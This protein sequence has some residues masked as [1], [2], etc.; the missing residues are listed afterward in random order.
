MTVEVIKIYDEYICSGIADRFEILKLRIEVAKAHLFFALSVPKRSAHVTFFAFPKFCC[1][2][3]IFRRERVQRVGTL[4][5]HFNQKEKVLGV[6]LSLHR[7][8]AAAVHILTPK[9]VAQCRT[10][11]RVARSKHT[12]AQ[13]G[14]ML[15]HP[16]R[17]GRTCSN[18]CCS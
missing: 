4:H 9:R 15:S 17:H 13:D 1:C 6:L 5:H 8:T 2:A 3:S 11:P 7:D 14:A 16:R 12:H 10:R 18:D